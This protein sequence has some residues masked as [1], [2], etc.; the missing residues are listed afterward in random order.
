MEKDI[1]ILNDTWS[2]HEDI[3]KIYEKI[4]KCIESNIFDDEY[5]NINIEH[6]KWFII[7]YEKNMS[8]KTLDDLQN[9]IKDI[10]INDEE[11]LR[12]C[13]EKYFIDACLNCIMN[14]LV[15]LSAGFVECHR[16]NIDDTIYDMSDPIHS[17]RECFQFLV[18]TE[19]NKVLLNT[20][21]HNNTDKFVYKNILN[22]EE[23]IEINI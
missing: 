9:I 5:S 3:H 22:L 7:L 2:S 18:D 23:K 20:K 16:K 15:Y 17:Y 21:F 19:I 8:V 4:K 11:Y 13:Y 10:F 1:E 12:Y 6:L 14:Q